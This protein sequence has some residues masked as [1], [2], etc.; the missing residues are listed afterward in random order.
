VS[1]Y[2]GLAIGMI[3]AVL[4][5]TLLNSYQFL[6]VHV[7]LV[8]VAVIAWA[9]LRRLENGLLWAVIGG[10]AVDVASAVPFGTSIAGLALAALAASAVAG[11]V[12]TIHPFLVIASLPIGLLTYYCVAT[13]LL[14]LGGVPVN[15]AALTTGVILPAVAVDSAAGLLVL[16]ILAWVSRAITPQPWTPQ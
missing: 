5:A 1:G 10:A 13:L 14:A 12:R 16:A 6:G 4:Q 7:D 11:P 8:P 15:F 2:L 9:A 3:G